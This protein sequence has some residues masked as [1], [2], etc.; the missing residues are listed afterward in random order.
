MV[1]FSVVIPL[2]N[3][4]AQIKNTIKSVINQTFTDFEIIIINDG[5]TDNSET[6][7]VEC[8][9]PRIQIYNQKNQ[10]V[11]TA[12]NLG[13]EKSNGKLIAF[14]DADDDWFPNHLQE[15]AYLY[16]DFPNCGIYC[17]RHKIKTSKN[18]FQIPTYNGVDQ[19]YRGI[20]KDYFFSNRPFRIT[21]T[22]SLAIPKEIIEQT[23]GFT[24]EV[25]NGQDLE[26]WTKIGIKYPVAITNQITAVYNYNIPNSLA[27][28][29]INT[30]KL[31]DFE[32][33]KLSEKQ[34]PS[35]KNF[36]DLYRI[37]YG[38]RYYIFGNKEKANF[39]LKDVDQQNISLKIRILMNIPSIFL[40]FF[41]KLKNTLKRFGINFSIYN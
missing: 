17:S 20:V 3:K 1:F 14:L 27:K 4:A 35:L 19:S 39:Y 7:A 38:L 15:L 33:F 31:M 25:T 40:R 26:L 30:M 36:L 5:S 32:Q 16:R 24:P 2:Y 11:S 8:N 41:L 28:N 18:I 6:L 23:G 9:D 29:H 21:W 10:G 13:I 37:E 22:S 34:S 12:R